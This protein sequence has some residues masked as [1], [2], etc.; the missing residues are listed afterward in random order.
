[1]NGPRG[2]RN[3]VRTEVGFPTAGDPG[4]I[5]TTSPACYDTPGWNHVIFHGATQD[6]LPCFSVKCNSPTSLWAPY[7]AEKSSLRICHSLVSANAACAYEQTNES[8]CFFSSCS[9]SN[10]NSC[11]QETPQQQGT[12]PQFTAS[13][14]GSAQLGWNQLPSRALQSPPFQRSVGT[15][16][17]N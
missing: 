1:M 12:R 6:S 5:R 13:T 4:L 17:A 2:I 10:N 9:S 16:A 7:I 15:M 3:L 11:R 8:S 14:L